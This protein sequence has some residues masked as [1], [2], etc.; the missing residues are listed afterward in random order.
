MRTQP[1]T[2]DKESKFFYL[3]LALVFILPLWP[4]YA[5]LKFGG[6]PNLAPDR[7]LRVA[8]FFVFVGT[9]FTN[10]AP[11]KVMK[12]R[13]Q[14]HWIAVFLLTTFY[15]I[16][17]LSALVSPNTIFQLYAFFRNEFLVTFPIL[18]YA[19]L[20]LKDEKSV[21]K[22]LVT[23]VISGFFASIVALVDYYKQRNLFMG[24]VPVSSDYLMGVFLDKTRDDNYRAQGTFEHPIMLGQF[25]ILL[26]PVIWTLLRQS[27]KFMSMIFYSAAGALALASI[28]VSGS[29]A[30]LGL[31]L[32]VIVLFV[33]WEIYAWT[34]TS[35]NRVLQYL[36][37]SQLPIPIVGAV[38]AIYLYKDNAIGRTQETLS[39]TNARIDMLVGGTP[40]IFES[41]IY[42]HGLG[43]HLQVFSLVGRA[44]IRTLDNF[45]LL[46]GLES[47]LIAVCA[48][49]VFFTICVAKS[50]FALRDRAAEVVRPFVAIAIAI[51][52]Y[53][54]QMASHSLH[55]QMW[56]V[57]LFASL[58]VALDERLPNQ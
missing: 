46:I 13:I 26:L 18:F 6:I 28:Y 40:K 53:A 39:S 36:V 52:V 29:R 45:Y 2:T 15:G 11:V 19:L 24:L 55:Q 17:I 57:L 27:S 7:L 4:N 10:S 9:F 32:V 38:F 3:F 49:I 51:F 1:A 31:S 50:Q 22:A 5:E 20:A 21:K 58:T 30:A 54:I 41:P 23:L 48:L 12:Q 14:K 56:I 42:G 8:L 33:F 16:R 47:G 35:K 34:K 44:G 37:M 25:F 43:E